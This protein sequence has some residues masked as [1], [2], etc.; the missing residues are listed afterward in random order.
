MT[1][2]DNSQ[3]TSFADSEEMEPFLQGKQKGTTFPKKVNKHNFQTKEA[4]I[5]NNMG[6]KS[7]RNIKS[8]WN[9]KSKR[10]K[11]KS[12]RNSKIKRNKEK[13]RQKREYL[14]DNKPK[15]EDLSA[16]ALY[17]D[18]KNLRNLMLS[19]FGSGFDL[20]ILYSR[21]SWG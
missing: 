21:F 5:L 17:F 14:E 19:D 8:K 11:K 20:M 2:P 4:S 7:K 18:K 12:K 15:F 1:N 9:N 13:I 6:S 10:N 16:H 3:K